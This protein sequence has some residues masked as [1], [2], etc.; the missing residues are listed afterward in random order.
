[1]KELKEHLAF[2]Q[3]L[4]KDNL[5]TNNYVYAEGVAK[6]LKLTILM[7]QQLEKYIPE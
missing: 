4:L 7:I 3:D 6:D 2:L 1:M 5:E